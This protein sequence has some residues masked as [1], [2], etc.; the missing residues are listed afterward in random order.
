MADETVIADNIEDIDDE[1]QQLYEHF[2]VVVDK[3][4]DPVRIDK[5][6]FE[7]LQHSSRNR[8]QKAAEAGF[9]HVNDR[10]VKSNY[11]VRPDD[12]VTLM[13]D[14]PRHDTTIEPEDIPLDVVY[15]DDDVMVINKPA[16]LVVHPGVGCRFL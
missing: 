12:V 5:F 11:K 4:Q 6:L 7:H 1:E 10:P 14:R 9:I 8:I 3:G 13:L 16:G 15:E 2:R